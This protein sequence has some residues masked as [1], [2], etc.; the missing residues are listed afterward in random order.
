MPCDDDP[1]LICDLDGTILR[2]NSFPW[3]VAYLV[4]GRLPELGL[5]RRLIL[6]LR[7]QQ[8]LLRRK[9]GRLDH[10]RLMRGLQDAWYHAGGRDTGAAAERVSQVARRQVRPEVDPVLRQIAAGE[11]DA[12]LA[13]AAAGEY[14]NGLGRQ[15]GFRHVLAT[16]VRLAPGQSL[17]AGAAKLSRVIEFLAAQYWTARPLVLLT[18]H[19]DDLPLIQYS[20]AVGW[21]GSAAAMAR[22][23]ALAA[24]TQFTLCCGLDASTLPLALAELS[25]HARSA[26]G[27]IVYQVP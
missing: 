16:P 27:A 25:A 5:R 22:A 1:V 6:S 21:F 15:L 14:A 7:V 23:G 13:T 20:D 11:M 2:G 17:N 4:L 24:G 18:D 8:L 26:A 10:A 3:W 12:V 9:L 19:I